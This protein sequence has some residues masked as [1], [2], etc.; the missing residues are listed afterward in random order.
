MTIRTLLQWLFI[1]AQLAAFS[2]G[3]LLAAGGEK[4]TLVVLNKSDASASLIALE[5]G[6]VVSTVKTGEGPHEAAVSPD[7]RIA[8][9]SNY[10]R[11]GAP[12]STLTLLQIPKQNAL[13]TIDLGKY[14][15]PHGLTFLPDGRHVLVTCEVQKKLLVVNL[16]T[17]KVE[18]T[19]DTGQQVSH[20]VVYSPAKHLAFVANIGS[21]TV[22]VIDLNKGQRVK[23]IATGRGAE[24]IDLS[25][26]ETEVWVANRADSTVSIIDVNRLSVAKTLE[27]GAFPI[28]VKF[29][30]DGRYVLVSNARSGDISVF[31]ARKRRQV[32]RISLKATPVELQ[33]GRLFGQGF[34]NGPVPVG[35][36]IPPDGRYA[37][38]ANTNADM[39]SVIDLGRWQV[40]QRLKTGHEPDG[41][42]YSPISILKPAEK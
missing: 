23:I 16:Q 2:G 11:R 24:G 5:T 39:V 36:L 19:F 12:G 38:V 6:K 3:N 1:C 26:D 40:V 28:R 37:F 27:A 9:V 42:G 34:A 25:P 22:S 41:M 18:K 10:G 13:R 33:E 8:V 4:G 29:T 20:M 32:R 31:D 30:P 15:R 17:G 35:V 14:Q 7:G 21:G